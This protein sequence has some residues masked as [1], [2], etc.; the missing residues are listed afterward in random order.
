METQLKFAWRPSFV[1]RLPL[2]NLMRGMLKLRGFTLK[3]TR[4]CR[5]PGRHGIDARWIGSETGVHRGH[6]LK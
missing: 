5:R 3:D 1:D 2:E 4:S 6:E